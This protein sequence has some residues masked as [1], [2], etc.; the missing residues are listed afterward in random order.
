MIGA[1]RGNYVALRDFLMTKDG[2]GIY[3]DIAKIKAGAVA[4]LKPN[5]KYQCMDNWWAECRIQR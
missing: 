3:K 5:M 1:F 2:N 4:G